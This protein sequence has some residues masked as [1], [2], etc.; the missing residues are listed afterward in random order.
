MSALRRIRDLWRG[1]TDA[2][3]RSLSVKLGTI[4]PPGSLVGLTQAE[5]K[6]LHHRAEGDAFIE[7]EKARVHARLDRQFATLEDAVLEERERCAK[8]CEEIMENSAVSFGFRF[9]AEKCAAAIRS[10][11]AKERE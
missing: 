6:A 7:A 9:G 8:L 1:Y 5:A 4:T 2:D 11:P 3:L 10:Q